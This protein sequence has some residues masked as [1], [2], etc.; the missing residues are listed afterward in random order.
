MKHVFPYQKINESVGRGSIVLV[1]GKNQ[2]LYVT[3]VLGS[4]QLKAGARML[5]LSDEFYRV[6][7]KD[8]RLVPVRV[9]FRNEESLMGVLNLK[10]PG[11]VS[12]VVNNKKTPLHWKTLKHINLYSALR[13]LE[14]DLLSGEF[15]LE[16]ESA[17]TRNKIWNDL[18]NLLGQ[19]IY[20]TLFMGTD[21]VKLSN[22]VMADS[23]NDYFDT[24]EADER[25]ATIDWNF[26]VEVVDDSKQVQK[27]LKYFNLDQPLIC[28]FYFS[29][30][31]TFSID[32]EPRS[33]DYPGNFE[34]EL[35]NVTHEDI[36]FEL[37][38][39]GPIEPN[40]GF[41]RLLDDLKKMMNSKG[42]D[43]RRL[44]SLISQTLKKRS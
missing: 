6:K 28:Y 22:Y 8:G 12:I 42:Y 43:D 3:H 24:V 15:I 9:S 4:A 37:E 36:T 40:R 1:K 5:F 34:V 33:L 19:R 7:S 41:K 23:I 17:D 31:V 13:E 18:G 10:V 39:A 25:S 44:D 16:S 29:T 20:R 27:Y 38:G 30:Y 2:K 11:R 21:E 35:D 32:S 26:S 14:P